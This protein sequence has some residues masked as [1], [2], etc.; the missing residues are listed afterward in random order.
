MPQRRP[1]TKSTGGCS[2]CKKRRIKCDESGPPCTTCRA[3]NA[4]CE[5]LN[6]FRASSWMRSTEHISR[7]NTIKT[8]R[9]PHQSQHVPESD[10]ITPSVSSRNRELQLM[11]HWTLH[12]C[13]SFSAIF[14]EI[15]QTCAVQ[16]ALHYPYLMD[17]LLALTSLHM[18]SKL[19]DTAEK[20][21]LLEDALRY[22]SQA[23]PVFRMELGNV[24]PVNCHA[25]FAC[26]VITMACIFVLPS[27]TSTTEGD[28]EAQTSTDLKSLFR[29]VSGT[30]SIID[31]ARVSLEA[32]PFK[33]IIQP[34]SGANPAFLPPGE[35]VLPMEL[36]TLCEVSLSQRLYE[37]AV[38]S[39]E[40]Y[41]MAEGMVIPWIMVAGEEFIERVQEREPLALLIYVCWAALMARQEMWWAKTAGMTIVQNYRRFE[42]DKT[43]RVVRWAREIAKIDT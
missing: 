8:D 2:R 27:L 5:Y 18:A 12:T 25:L 24:T 43:D 9:A 38:D 39:L 20:T 31:R 41:A 36:K 3:R 10:P 7:E 32:G 21:K 26:S 4:D 1:H 6:A 19:P 13:H 30:H 37:H 28:V 35:R 34:W 16:Q 11:H 40:R 33:M 15:F 29:L 17:S 42:S 14:S 22:Q 23:M